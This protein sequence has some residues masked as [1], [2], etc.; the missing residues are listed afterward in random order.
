MPPPLTPEEIRSIRGP[1]TQAEFAA[2]LGVSPV[3]VYRWEL[4][5]GA[6]QSRTPRRTMQARIRTLAGEAPPADGDPARPPPAHRRERGL[7]PEELDRFLSIL[8]MV[9]QARWREAED[10]VL[11]FLHAQDTCVGMRSFA[12]MIMAQVQLFERGDV[13]SALTSLQPALDADGEA[14]LPTWIAARIH[15]TA[16]LVFAHPDGRIF[17]PG[18]VNLSAARAEALLP[19]TGTEDLHGLL[20]MAR[21]VAAKGAGDAR[22]ASQ[23]I[24]RAEPMLRATRSPLLKVLRTELC[25][26]NAALTGQLVRARQRLSEAV[27]LAKVHGVP[28]ARFRAEAK[29]AWLELFSGEPYEAVRTRVVRAR[30]FADQARL[31]S[32]VAEAI[33]EATSAEL[34]FRRG[35]FE[36]AAT[37]LARA[38]ESQRIRKLVSP[39]A[40]AIATRVVMLRQEDGGLDAL[41]A[42]LEESLQGNAMAGESAI[43][44]YLR[45]MRA[46]AEGN[47]E[48]AARDLL[49]AEGDVREAGCPLWLGLLAASLA[50]YCAL[51]AGD[52]ET[53]QIA[54]R[55]AEKALE[56]YPAAWAGAFLAGFQAMIAAAQGRPE[57]ARL[58]IESAVGTF[59][60]AGD[61][62]QLAILGRVRAV[63]AWLTEAPDADSELATSDAELRALGLPTPPALRVQALEDLRARMLE[64]PVMAAPVLE[65]RELLVPL[66]RLTLR[67]QAPKQV[68][69]ELLQAVAEL[70]G[71]ELGWVC[72][73]DST[74]KASGFARRGPSPSDLSPQDHFEFGDG[75][76]RRFRLGLVGP[77]PAAQRPVLQALAQ[78]AGQ[79]MEIGA[80]RSYATPSD[81]VAAAASAPEIHGMVARSKA[82]RQVAEDLHRLRHS[83]ATVLIT[84]ES[85]T[86]KEVVA[87]ALHESSRRAREAYVTFNCSTVPRDLFEGQLFGYR[88]GAF[89]GASQDHPG[90]IRAA[91]GGTLLLDEVG[92]LPLDLQPKLLRFLEN[93]EVLPLGETSPHR[94]DVRVVA[95]THKDLADLVRQGQFREDLFFR[96]QVVPIHLAPLRERPED[97]V[98]LIEHFLAAQ[99]EEGE[100]PPRLAPEVVAELQAYRWPGNAREVRNVVERATAYTPIPRVLG[101][102][103]LRLG[104]AR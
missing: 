41:E 69:D 90:V 86:G 36:G 77:V 21:F 102:E 73:L 33:L 40:L 22:L 100:P 68:A 31:T 97:V 98:P 55:R 43:R 47:F 76:G 46:L 8:D 62:V 54:S 5:D 87:R 37:A 3:T 45:G 56:R 104:G 94:V 82:M 4:Q 60:R 28:T 89:T 15:V 59:A 20:A 16:A 48:V 80:L 12:Q 27:E 50:S 92:D 18:R 91:D 65:A 75:C 70:T 79:A 35:D 63:V 42:Q 67:G 103:H 9:L 7:R 30:R 25:G 24:S 11:P 58:H 26:Y 57:D 101:P 34:A 44:L 19:A 85:G 6:G 52:L 2:L 83:R 71:E 51:L 78:V 61:R 99:L 38:Q 1:R 64:T 95:A 84:G 88:K 14:G 29:L 17:H 39:E 23:V 10:A 72:E 66:K 81:A 96:L 93:A 32:D 53:S 74:G 49:A 13:R